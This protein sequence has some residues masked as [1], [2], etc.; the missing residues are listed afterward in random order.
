M[1]MDCKQFRHTVLTEPRTADAEFVQHR[2]GCAVCS[3]FAARAAAFESKLARALAIEV[4]TPLRRSAANTAVPRFVRAIP[5]RWLALAASVLLGIGVVT[6]LWLAKPTPTLAAAL[7]EHLSHEPGAWVAP[8]ADVSAETLAEVLKA[9]RLSLRPT[10]GEVRYARVC[11]FR[12]RD[13]PHLVVQQ[14]GRPVTVMILTKEG[15]SRPTPFAEGAY[16]GIIEPAP[17][18][19]IAVMARSSDAIDVAQAAAV[20]LRAIDGW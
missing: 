7:V 14:N 2:D 8:A 18:G 11:H 19:S 12:G 15:V 13:V 17:R 9:D 20:V 10:G 5:Q 6:I 4:K 16:R 3:G 1:T